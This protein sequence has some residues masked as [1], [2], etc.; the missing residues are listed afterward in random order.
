MST[1]KIY[2]IYMDNNLG[3]TGAQRHFTNQIK[4]YSKPILA[5]DGNNYIDENS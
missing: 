4:H 3:A 5:T 1:A 2:D